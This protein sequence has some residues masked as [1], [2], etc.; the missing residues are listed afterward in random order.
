MPVLMTVASEAGTRLGSEATLEVIF[1]LF[2]F[3]TVFNESTYLKQ[4]LN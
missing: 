4:C 2:C 3:E 1:I